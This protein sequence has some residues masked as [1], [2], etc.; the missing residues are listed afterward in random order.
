M[1]SEYRC[2][3]RSIFIFLTHKGDPWQVSR[4]DG[5]DK[6]TSPGAGILFFSCQCY[7]NKYQRSWLVNMNTLFS[8]V[9]V[10]CTSIK[11]SLFGKL[12]QKNK[13]QAGVIRR[14]T[15]AA[16]VSKTLPPHC[17]NILA[18]VQ[19]G[20]DLRQARHPLLHLHEVF[21][22]EV[23]AKL[24]PIQISGTIYILSSFCVE[25]LAC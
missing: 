9:N 7:L 25:V 11:V 24:A 4:A 14:I 20:V 23:L 13:W 6:S 10:T 5:E 8:L 3:P 2:L 21:A 17:M 18:F 22:R 1:S 12:S 16:L 19:G 15:C